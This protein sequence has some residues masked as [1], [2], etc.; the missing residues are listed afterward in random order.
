MIESIH[1]RRRK[2]L[3]NH[4][5]VCGLVDCFKSLPAASGGGYGSDRHA[6]SAIAGNR[7]F[8]KNVSFLRVLSSAMC[9]SS[10]FKTS[11]QEG[12]PKTEE[13]KSEPWWRDS[14]STMDAFPSSDLS[15]HKVS[16]ATPNFDRRPHAHTGRAIYFCRSWGNSLATCLIFESAIL[17]LYK[18]V[19]VCSIRAPPSGSMCASGIASKR[20]QEPAVIRAHITSAGC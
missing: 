2:L 13:T 8:R 17:T 15:L 19:T 12:E 1:H 18:S 16:P 11:S 10:P 4:Y 14:G 9:G 7:Q 6:K 3:D 20:W 5:P